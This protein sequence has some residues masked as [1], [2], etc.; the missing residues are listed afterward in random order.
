MDPIQFSIYTEGLAQ[1]EHVNRQAKQTLFDIKEQ[2]YKL[3]ILTQQTTTC[4]GS[5]PTVIG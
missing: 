4:D 3:R 1:I 5:S 2:E